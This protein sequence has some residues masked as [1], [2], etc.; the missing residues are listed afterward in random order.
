MRRLSGTQKPLNKG[1]RMPRDSLGFMYARGYGVQQNYDEALKWYTK[2]AKQG[3]G[4]AQQTLGEMYYNGEGVPKDYN[5]ALKWLTMSVQSIKQELNKTKELEKQAGLKPWDGYDR[6]ESFMLKDTYFTLGVMYDNGRGTPRDYNEAVK[7]YKKAAETGIPEAQYN[8][9]NMYSIGQGVTKDNE[10]AVKWY[11]KAAEQG[12]S[13]AQLNLGAMY[14]YGKGIS[15]DYKEA[16]KWYKKSAE[17]DNAKAQYNLSLIYYGGHGV[18]EDYIEAYKWALLA[19]MNGNDVTILKQSLS[20]KMTLAQINKAQKLAKEFVSQKENAKDEESLGLEERT[21]P[22]ASGTG[23]FINPSGYMI[24]AAHVVE[25]ARSL[26]I[27]TPYGKYQAKIILL[28]EPSDV[29]IL[30]VASNNQPTMSLAQLKEAGFSDA[31]ISDHIVRQSSKIK[32]FYYLEIVSSSAVAV[33]DKIFT[34]GFPNVPIQGTEPKYTDGTIS[35][36]SGIDNNIRHF[37]ISIPVQPGNS[38]G[39]LLSAKG[40]IIGVIVSRLDDIGMLEA[41]GT[42]PQN[43]NY[44]VKSAFILPL[45]ENLPAGN[46]QRPNH[47]MKQ[48]AIPK[49]SIKPETQLLSSSFIDNSNIR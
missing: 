31:E 24:T 30:K 11:T 14:Q 4:S 43:V 15:Q 33:G 27:F 9:G 21:S 39:P 3:Y 48:W 19:G 6:E 25:K 12:Y 44:A 18:I 34:I 23:F 26:Q 47:M 7:W 42:L 41:T 5:E 13:D 22:K 36:L 1:T 40:E 38:G 17:Q 32:D 2:A 46:H 10:E 20:A 35:S 29:A 28:D 45:L 49:L 16:V 37:Q 8:L